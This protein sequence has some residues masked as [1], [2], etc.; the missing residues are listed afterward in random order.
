MRRI[1][2]CLLPLLLTFGG[3]LVGPAMAA[4]NRFVAIG[5]GGVT[6]VYY[7]AGA[8]I[9]RLLNQ[10]R[11][12]HGIHCA[13]ESTSGSVY[14]LN[15][16]KSGDFDIGIVQSD[17]QYHAYRG[18][19]HFESQGPN[20]ELRALFSLHPEAFTVVARSDSGIHE[21]ADLKGKRVN[22]GNPGSGQRGTMEVVMAAFGWEKN[23]FAAV[24]E[25]E[26]AE[27]SQALCENKFDAMVFTVGHPSGSIKE[28]TSSCETVLVDVAG[29]VI[30]KLVADNEY[31]LPV[32]I[33]G[34]MY[35]GGDV[36]VK[37]FGVGATVVTSSKLEDE[38]AYHVVK[39]VFER[40][41]EF[42]KQHPAFFSLKKEQ[43][44][45][46]GLSAPLH[47]GAIKYF[48]EVGLL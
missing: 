27:Q 6:A 1:V 17:W 9:C 46:D 29:P 12:E 38:V 42:R 26:S 44:V 2:L 13:A 30:D 5:T 41:V 48:K 4:E 36:G 7:P 39:V 20:K 16:I 37:T 43:M 25:L 14:N 33:S 45:I 31:Y 10:G 11:A 32:T 34:G 24:S 40:F 22:I 28:A 18:T 47:P 3:L 21:F 19:S 23:D 35:R 15:A 8:A